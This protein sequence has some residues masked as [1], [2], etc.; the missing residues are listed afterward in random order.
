MWTSFLPIRQVLYNLT[1]VSKEF[2]AD[3]LADNSLTFS[4]KI[5]TIKRVDKLGKIARAN[6]I[7][8]ANVDLT[9]SQDGTAPLAIKALEDL[10]IARV[11][12][13]DKVI[14]NV[15][16]TYPAASE[17]VANFHSLMRK[18]AIQQGC[19]IQEGNVC[20]QYMLEHFVVP[21]MLIVGA[22]SHTTMQGALGAFATGV[23]STEIATVWASGRIWLRVPESIRIIFNG[24]LPKGIFSKDLILHAIGRLSCEGAN[25]RAVEFSGTTT[26][27]LSIDSRATLCNMS[28]ETGAKVGIVEVDEVTINY[29]DSLGRTSLLEVHAGKKANYALSMKVNVEKMEP[30][31]AL[32]HRVDNVKPISEVEG[33]LINQAFLGSCTNARLEDLTIAADVLRGRR[34]KE[35]VRLI[36]TPASQ[37]VYEEALR[38]G[39]INL[40]IGA[41]ALVTNPTCG[42]CVG[43]HLG[44]L[45]EGEV[46]I[47]SSNR[48]FIGRMGARDSKVFLASPA[49]VAASAIRGEIC[50]PREYLG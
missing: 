29:I 13:S 28:A 21:G 26:K 16:H 32:P 44:V 37:R 3:V 11:W 5:L 31:V 9:M 30:L 20:H 42:A 18:F 45:G 7:I 33:Q 50:D 23:G 17:Q 35:G 8:V 19:H 4:E 39:V 48:N 24:K 22:D 14:L 41:G 2:F 49:T 46:C 38:N 34:V 43:T 27:E 1:R 15:D 10:G 47:S 12:D 40:L 36:V 6:G 25:Y